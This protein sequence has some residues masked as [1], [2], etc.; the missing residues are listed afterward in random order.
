MAQK[1]R[2]VNV[3][4]E[5]GLNMSTSVHIIFKDIDKTFSFR[6]PLCSVLFSTLFL[7]LIE[8]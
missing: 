6:A 3:K 8:P 2:N 5:V 4:S 1:E 7:S